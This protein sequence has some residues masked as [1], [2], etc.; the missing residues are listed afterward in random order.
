[1]TPIERSAAVRYAASLTLDYR[2]ARRLPEWLRNVSWA[3]AGVAAFVAI[4]WLAA[5]AI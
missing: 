2:R 5:Q 1:M 4:G 3:A